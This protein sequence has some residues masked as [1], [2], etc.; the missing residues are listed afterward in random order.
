[1]NFMVVNLTFWYKYTNKYKL[2]YTKKYI[3]YLGW[4]TGGLN[5]GL[6]TIELQN[7]GEKNESQ[8]V[9][10]F[11]ICDKLRCQKANRKLP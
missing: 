1:M 5:V 11:S 8:G 3:L 10:M 2:I 7:F 4:L 6:P 9:G